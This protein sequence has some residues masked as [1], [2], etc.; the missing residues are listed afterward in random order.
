M[1]Q[2]LLKKCNVCKA[3]IIA[4]DAKRDYYI[5]PKC[6]SYFRMHAYRRME[7]ILDEGSLEEWDRELSSGNPLKY[8]DYEEKVNAL[9]EKTK[10]D[11]G[12]ITGM[13]RIHGIPVVIGV[14]DGRFMMASMGKVVGEKIAKAVERQQGKGFLSFYLPVL[15]EPECRKELFLLCR[16]QRQRLL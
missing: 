4:E 6:G 8:K 7:M 15:G 3:A 10:L 1:P 14:C 11:E 16:W 9:R 13:G 2:G 12:I 5:C